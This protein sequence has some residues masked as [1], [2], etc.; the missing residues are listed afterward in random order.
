MRLFRILADWRGK[1]AQFKFGAEEDLSNRPARFSTNPWLAIIFATFLFAAN[2]LNFVRA[3]TDPPKGWEP[4]YVSRDIG[5]GQH[6]AWANSMND[7]WVVPNFNASVLTKPGM[8]TPRMWSV[9]QVARLGARSCFARFTRCFQ[10][11]PKV[12]A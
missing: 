10:R 8:F 9:G 11:M 6:L 12:S 4:T 5:M 3:W 7:H 2:N 1:V